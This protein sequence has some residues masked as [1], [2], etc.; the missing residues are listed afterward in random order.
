MGNIFRP[1]RGLDGAGPEGEHSPVPGRAAVAAALLAARFDRGKPQAID[2]RA[3]FNA[4]FLR[5]R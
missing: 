3:A 2:V 1:G 4:A 5:R